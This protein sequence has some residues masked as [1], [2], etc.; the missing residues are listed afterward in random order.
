MF[1]PFLGCGSRRLRRLFCVWVLMF[2][3]PAISMRSLSDEFK[4]G[5][6]ELLITKPISSLKIVLGKYF[7]ILIILLLV[8]VRVFCEILH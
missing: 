8:M 4:S 6:F 5:T 2:L 1:L 7:A 3:I